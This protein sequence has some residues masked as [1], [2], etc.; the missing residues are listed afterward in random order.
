MRIYFFLLLFFLTLPCCGQCKEDLCKQVLASARTFKE[1]EPVYNI[2]ARERN[3]FKYVPTAKPIKG[4][5]RISSNFGNRFHPISKKKKFHSGL[6]MAAQYATTVHCAASGTV[7]FAG[8]TNG[9]GKKVVVV[10]RYGFVTCY[11]HLTYIYA[12]I[13]QRVKK[14]ECIGFVGSTGMSTGN[15]L[16]YEII[17]NKRFINPINFINHE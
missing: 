4:R 16:H 11:A 14:G 8:I 3:I 1:I 10:H 13:G 2:I 9:Y 7:T 12:K 6:D 17:K 5:Y 15:H